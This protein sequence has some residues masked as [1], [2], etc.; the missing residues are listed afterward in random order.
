MVSEEQLENVY[1]TRKYIEENEKLEPLKVFL[2]I[3]CEIC[4]EPIQEWI[5]KNIFY[6]KEGYR[7]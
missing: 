3:K 6:A 1:T 5:E 4:G 7:R 2:E